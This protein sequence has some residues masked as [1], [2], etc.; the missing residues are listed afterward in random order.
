MGR[1]PGGG[2]ERDCP[3]GIRG[4]RGKTFEGPL[5]AVAP[6]GRG[7]RGGTWWRG[8]SMAP[9][10]RSSRG[11]SVG[12][13]RGEPSEEG[14]IR[15][16]PWSTARDWSSEEPRQGRCSGEVVSRCQE[17]DP[18][19]KAP[20]SQPGRALDGRPLLRPPRRCPKEDT[21]WKASVS[22]P[23]RRCRPGSHPVG[24]SLQDP[25]E[26]GP[27]EASPLERRPWQELQRAPPG[28]RSGRQGTGAGRERPRRWRLRG[29]SA[30][31]EARGD[32]PRL[33]PRREER[34]RFQGPATRARLR[35]DAPGQAPPCPDEGRKNAP[36]GD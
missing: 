18:P 21:R 1:R 3:S 13:P 20:R 9:P 11:P 34:K 24:E 17:R 12:D 16:I 10:R 27:C 29:A 6:P 2:P 25:S 5:S 22:A 4:D 32:P 36:S 14:T 31:G 8:V 35:G 26:E 23:P 7:C 28:N 30:G 15:E 33:P 19:G